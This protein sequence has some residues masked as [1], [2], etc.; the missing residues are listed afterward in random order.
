MNVFD[1]YHGENIE[2]GKYSI[3]IAMEFN[4]IVSTLTDKEVD[5]AVKIILEN[6]KKECKANI[7]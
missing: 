5:D 3:A 1:I 7:R 2:E 4:K 6:L